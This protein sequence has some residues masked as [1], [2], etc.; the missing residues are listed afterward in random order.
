MAVNSIEDTLSRTE[1]VVLLG[2]AYAHREELTPVQTHDLRR[3]CRSSLE[4]GETDLVGTLSEADVMRSL[5]T[6]EATDV[7]EEVETDGT[8]PTGKG[9]PSYTLAVGI[10]VILEGVDDDLAEW[11]L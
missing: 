1:Q 9:R 2:V 4:T 11:A 5:Y 8:S 6:L 10:D 3:L 7:V